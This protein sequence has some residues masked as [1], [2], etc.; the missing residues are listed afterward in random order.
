MTDSGDALVYHGRLRIP[1]HWAIGT[2]ASYFYMKLAEERKL[3]GTRCPAC[4]R[5]LFPPRASCPRC[6]A[7]TTDWVEVGPEGYVL[8]YTVVRYAKPEM[9]SAAPPLIYGLIRLNGADTGFI[10]RLSEIEPGALRTGL[11]VAARLRPS[12]QGN[13]LDIEYFT[14]VQSA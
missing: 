8:S 7:E 4:T 6:F 13:I 1:Y 11:R 2:T 12:P 10:H 3:L 14:P 9:Q 5:V